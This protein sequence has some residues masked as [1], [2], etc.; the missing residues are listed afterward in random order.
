MKHAFFLLWV[1]LAQ[2]LFAQSFT[3]ETGDIYLG[4]PKG[5][6]YGLITVKTG[7]LKSTDKWDIYA[8]SGFKYTAQLRRMTDVNSKAPLKEL[9]AGQ[10]AYVDFSTANES[11]KYSD[12]L[13]RGCQV[14]PAGFQANTAAIKAETESKIAKSISFQATLNGKSFRAKTTYRGASFWRK[15]VKNYL[16]KP[17]LQ[18]QF[19]S[20]DQP[21][22]RTLT[23]QVL[24]PKESPALY[25]A[26]DLEVNF[27]GATDGNPKN[28]T[29]YG[30]VNGKGNTDFRVEIIKWQKKSTDRAV[31]SGK[32]TGDLREVKLIGNGAKTNRF[33]YGV[34]ENIEVE[35][36]NQQPD[37]KDMMKASGGGGLLKN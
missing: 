5:T 17:Y 34:F 24:N 27:S 22:D 36:F 2:P 6:Y 31:V 26:K 16:E 8:E 13:R 20:V 10:S 30:F 28:T 25:T 3:A 1:V 19:G 35:I 9:K 32:V 12:G 29:L 7:V 4:E 11:N 37:L 14:Y 21:D 33:E 18:L 15:G 23:I